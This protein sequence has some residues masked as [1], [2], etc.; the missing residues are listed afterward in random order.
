MRIIAKENTNMS[1][2]CRNVGSALLLV[3]FII[4]LLAAVVMGM[5]QINTEE[6][7]IMRNQI[8]LA[9]AQATAEAGMHDMFYRIQTDWQWDGYVVTEN[10]NG[11]SYTVTASGT[12]PNLTVESTGTS[13]QGFVCRAQVDLVVGDS[14]YPY[15]IR[16][17][18]FKIN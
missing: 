10:F 8:Y 14:P 6:I 16:L 3:I 2:K 12:K 11:G 4:A 17:N 1:L 15:P 13:A 9:E 18:N 5:L 7:Q